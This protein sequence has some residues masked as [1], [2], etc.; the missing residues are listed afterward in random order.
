M[1]PNNNNLDNNVSL[2][3]RFNRQ[4]EFTLRKI[5][6]EMNVYMQQNNYNQSQVIE[7]KKKERKNSEQDIPINNRSVSETLLEPIFST[8]KASISS[9]LPEPEDATESELGN[10]DNLGSQ[11]QIM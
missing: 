9:V 5:G 6:R 7:L 11:I 8:K 10:S 4:I 2:S 3:T 1:I